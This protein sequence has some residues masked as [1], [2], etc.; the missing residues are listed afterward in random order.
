[1]IS[2]K[3]RIDLLDK[4][5]VAIVGS[6]NCS[7]AGHAFARRIAAQLSEAGLVIVSGLARG[8]DGAAHAAALER[9]TVAVLAGGL[10]NIYPPEHAD[11]HN[12]IAISGWSRN[13]LRVSSHAARISRAA[14]GSS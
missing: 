7:A 3:G 4:P 14:T 2:A 10:D 13:A 8:I 9:G 11:L 12:E 5:A 6:H 1:M